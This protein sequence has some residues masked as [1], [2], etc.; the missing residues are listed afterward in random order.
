MHMADALISPAVGITMYAAAAGAGAFSVK[1]LRNE[2]DDRKIPLMGVMGAFVFAAQMINFTIPGTGSSGHLGG[3]ILLSIILG[4]YAGFI[5]MMSILL[6]QALFFADG[7]LLALGCNIINMGLFTCFIA[8]PFI[9]KK[10]MKK[11]FSAKRIYTASILA[12][13]AGLQIGSLGVVIETMISGKTNLPFKTFLFYMQPIH[14]AIGIVEGL[15][16][17]AIAGYVWK[18]RPDIIE[19]GDTD[20]ATGKVSFKKMIAVIAIAAIIT[21]GALS[22][23]ASSNPDG[24]EWSILKTAGTDELEPTDTLHAK[25]LEI[26]NNTAL[27]PDYDFRQ[28]EQQDDIKGSDKTNVNNADQ[29]KFV[30]NGGTSVSGLVGGA[31]TLLFVG[32]AGAIIRAFKKKK[33]IIKNKACES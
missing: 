2:I 16:T 7:G 19:N 6:I 32:V 31:M 5:T 22:W 20:K 3:G 18:V 10:I 30:V 28:K 4:P 25:A 1:K 13:V 24:L 9:Y 23:F 27:F 29:E 33:G 17:A 8:Y 12:S 15:I 14:L 21:G 11:G 26:Q